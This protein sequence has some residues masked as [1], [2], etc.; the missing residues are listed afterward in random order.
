MV[1][2]RLP[3]KQALRWS[4]ACRIL[5]A[6]GI[7]TCGRYEKKAGVGRGRNWSV[8]WPKDI[9]PRPL[10]SYGVKMALQSSLE[11][12]QDGHNLHIHINQ[13][14][15]EGHT[16]KEQDLGKECSLQLRQ[17]LK[18]LAYEGSLPTVLQV[19]VFTEGECVRHISVCPN[20]LNQ[21]KRENFFQ[22]LQRD[23]IHRP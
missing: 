2:A 19:Q 12:V 8:I 22:I 21:N 23:T 4:V 14:L 9:L 13:L 10:G 11:L 20:Y 17:C 16:E 7:N 15:D 6:L 5:S 18:R 3:M 1:Q